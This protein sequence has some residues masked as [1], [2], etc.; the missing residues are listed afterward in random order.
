VAEERPI[1]DMLP[2]LKKVAAALREA[3]IRFVLA[4]GMAAWARGGP[5]SDHD[6]DLVL[7]PED[8]E[9]ALS[10]LGDVGMRT[11]RPPEPW[12]YKVFDG[13]V[14]IDLIFAPAG[15]VIT[16]EVIERSDELE[17]WAVPMRVM[18]P[19]DILVTKLCAMTE[20]TTDYGPCLEIARSLR[21]QIDWDAVRERTAGSPFAAAFL[22][23]VEE[24]EIA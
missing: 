8:A 3:Q 12:L 13:D 7:R 6:V 22:T 24:L 23:L 4:G 2:S 19:E 14:M 16:D 1:D 5:E 18:R 10:V 20:H 17:V 15:L 21:E 11:E 9:R